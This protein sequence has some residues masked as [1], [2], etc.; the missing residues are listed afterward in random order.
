MVGAIQR[1]SNTTTNGVT[2]HTIF[3]ENVDG[4]FLLGRIPCPYLVGDLIEIT[5]REPKELIGRNGKPY[6]RYYIN[7]GDIRPIGDTPPRELPS[8]ADKPLTL[9]ERQQIEAQAL[10]E[11]ALATR[12]QHPS[13]SPDLREKGASLWD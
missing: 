1:I 5:V 3:L 9:A 7:L 11:Q 8:K 2:L 4:W 10:Y 6:K 12:K 13:R